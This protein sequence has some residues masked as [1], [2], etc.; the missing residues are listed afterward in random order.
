MPV[1]FL[2]LADFLNMRGQ[3]SVHAENL[4]LDDCCDRQVVEGVHK[5]VPRVVTPVFSINFIVKA[6][7]FCCETTFMVTPQKSNLVGVLDLVG[8][9]ESDGLNTVVA[10]VHVVAQEEISVFVDPASDVQQLQ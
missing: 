5:P 4:V 1:N 10:P 2:D 8:K 6:V 9:Q 7:V 3:S